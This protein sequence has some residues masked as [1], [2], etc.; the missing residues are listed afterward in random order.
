VGGAAIKV[1]SAAHLSW[2]LPAHTLYCQQPSELRSRYSID[3]ERDTQ[4]NLLLD[5]A[6]NPSNPIGNYGI[7]FAFFTPA[8]MSENRDNLKYRSLRKILTAP[9]DPKAAQRILQEALVEVVEALGIAAASIVIVNKGGERLLNVREG[10][11]V[12]LTLLGSLEERMLASMRADFGLENIY[13]T[14]NHEGEKSLFSYMIKAGGESLGAVSGICKGSRN[15]ALEEEFIEVI[16]TAL[17]YLFGQAGILDSAR[18]EAVKE[19]TI[20]LNHEINNPLTAVLG[21]VQLLLMKGKDLPEDVRNRLLMIEQSSLRIR[22]AVSKLLRI[23]EA[24]STKYLD[25]TRMIDLHD[26]EESDK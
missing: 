17:K 16:A 19:T 4:G 25:D 20:T 12:L 13:S 26:P 9:Q 7:E 3:I 8:T 24:K 1:K 22:D 15:I 23:K 10:E 6:P 21:N 14:L 11:P 2:L 18:V 5:E